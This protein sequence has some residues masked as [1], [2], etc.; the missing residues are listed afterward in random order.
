MK[1]K[2]EKGALALLSFILGVGV[3]ILVLAVVLSVGKVAT[4]ND[5]PLYDIIDYQYFSS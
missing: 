5:E 4:I 3:S 2:I 1:S